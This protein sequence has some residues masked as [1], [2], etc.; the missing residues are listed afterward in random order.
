MR[1]RR[2]G[3]RGS[4]IGKR[5]EEGGTNRETAIR[6]GDVERE[7]EL[8]KREGSKHGKVQWIVLSLWC[9]RAFLPLEKPPVFL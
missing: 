4:G 5:D 1:S 6:K 2:E 3:V 8:E 9:R 7:R